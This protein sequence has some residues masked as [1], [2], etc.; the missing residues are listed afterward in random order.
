MPKESDAKHEVI[1]PDSNSTH[2]TEAMCRIKS[3]TRELQQNKP[4]QK[5]SQTQL[6]EEEE[7]CQNQLGQDSKQLEGKL[8]LLRGQV[9]SF[10]LLHLENMCCSIIKAYVAI[11]SGL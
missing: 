11:N 10:T 1:G 5:V 6:K 4:L 7:V 8:K 9:L 2:S 3:I